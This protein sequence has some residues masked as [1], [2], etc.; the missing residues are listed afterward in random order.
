MSFFKAEKISKE[1]KLRRW[2]ILMLFEGSAIEDGWQGELMFPGDP[3]A[4]KLT[5]DGWVIQV[6]RRNTESEFHCTLAV[7][8]PDSLQITIPSNESG[9]VYDFD[10]MKENLRYCKNCESKNVDTFRY[11]F[12][13]RCCAECRTSLDKGR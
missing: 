9:P 3:D 11:S 8:G 6:V 1:E 4:V 13:G 12:A 2:T 5:K 7:F 10:K